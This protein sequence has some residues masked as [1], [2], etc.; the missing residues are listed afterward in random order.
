MNDQ[1]ADVR[2]VLLSTSCSY[3]FNSIAYD[4]EA[5]SS[6]I[7]FP[8]PTTLFPTQKLGQYQTV[9]DLLRF[10]TP[11]PVVLVGEQSVRKFRSSRPVEELPPPDDVAI[12]VG[13]WRVYL[14]NG[15]ADG[16]SVPHEVDE[17]EVAQATSSGAAGKQGDGSKLG[18]FA[19]VVCSVNVNRGKDGEEQV[20][21]VREWFERMVE[22]MEIKEYQL[23]IESELD[24]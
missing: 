8:T 15:R 20:K 10:D 2:S 11:K 18:R 24:V 12:F 6:R 4:N 22:S 7:T 17:E 19:D 3:H 21:K 13:L 9:D 16:K 5:L 23:F 1:Q 14:E